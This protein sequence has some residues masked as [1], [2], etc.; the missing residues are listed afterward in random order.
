MGAGLG[1]KREKA[2]LNTTKSSAKSS[3]SSYDIFCTALDKGTVSLDALYSLYRLLELDTSPCRLKRPPNAGADVTGRLIPIL[4]GWFQFS[5][6]KGR[7][8]SPSTP[9]SASPMLKSSKPA[10][11]TYSSS[12][13]S[14][15]SSSSSSSL[16]IEL[17]LSLYSA[18]S[19]LP[20]SPN[21][22][23][24]TGAEDVNR[25]EEA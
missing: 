1:L 8:G 18:L 2:G 7:R 5:I 25:A 6:S 21:G 23:M 3:S 15:S 16:T 17:S 9:A 24:S 14:S 10:S 4:L 13:L 19:S 11:S 12:S 22:S 20:S